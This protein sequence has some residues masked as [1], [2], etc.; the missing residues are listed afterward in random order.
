VTSTTLIKPARVI[1]AGLVLITVLVAAACGSSASSSTPTPSATATSSSAADLVKADW[2]AFFAGTTPAKTKITLLQNGTAFSKTIQAQAASPIAKGTQAQV[3]AVKV[4]S[5]TKA[6]V[7]YSILVNGQPALSDQT[8]EAVLEGGT[9]KVGTA[10][11][12]AL[13]AM[14]QQAG[15]ASPSPTN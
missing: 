2:Q 1:V 11:F 13:L 15:G 5:P 9:W 12:Q 6:T 4:V 8:G 7:T 10:S 3:T 14:E